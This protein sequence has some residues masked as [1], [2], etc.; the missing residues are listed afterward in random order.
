MH[1]KYAYD[2][3]QVRNMLNG[4][5]DLVGYCTAIDRLGFALST[6]TELQDATLTLD[7]IAEIHTDPEALQI[8]SAALMTHA[9]IAYCRATHSG[10]RGRKKVGATKKYTPDQEK[11]HKDIAE[12][13][14]E[15]IA[16]Y[17]SPTQ[18]HGLKWLD[19][20]IVVKVVDDAEVFSFSR[21][22]ANYLAAAI[23]DLRELL[24]AA[25][26]TV[27]E[28]IEERAEFLN[29][30]NLKHISDDRVV[31]ALSASPFDPYAFYGVGQLAD[32]FWDVTPMKRSETLRNG[33]W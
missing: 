29:A 20:R 16:H 8:V 15:V 26:A 1:N 12:L 32:A 30:L 4:H 9:I 7:A 6:L 10:G 23:A 17:G 28:V 22:R 19:E 18:G 21:N 14:N 33:D 25:T 11:K 13:R 3:T 2:L 31:E 27:E 5:D 24:A